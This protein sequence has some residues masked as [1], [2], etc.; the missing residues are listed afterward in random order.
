MRRGE[1][2]S[3][4]IE[5][6]NND[7]VPDFHECKEREFFV[8]FLLRTVKEDAGGRSLFIDMYETPLDYG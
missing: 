3:T 2:G 6:H 4:L 8:Y 1:A 5:R 7:P